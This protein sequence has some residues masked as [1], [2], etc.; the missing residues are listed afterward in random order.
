MPRGFKEFG[1]DVDC[2]NVVRTFG[3]LQGEPAIARAKVNDLHIGRDPH[4]GHDLVRSWPQSLPPT[5]CRHF[6]GVKEAW[7]MSG[8]LRDCLDEAKNSILQNVR[9]S[10]SQCQSHAI[11]MASKLGPVQRELFLEGRGDTRSAP[12]S[13][14]V[15][16]DTRVR[17]QSN[18]CRHTPAKHRV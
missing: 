17:R 16:F 5:R 7:G 2:D 1:L 12:Q 3:D 6:G 4:S 18:T 11:P 10:V 8:H 15:F 13:L 14:T 9:R